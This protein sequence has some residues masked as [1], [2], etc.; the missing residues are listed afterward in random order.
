VALRECDTQLFDS[1]DQLMT[2]TS[3]GDVEVTV[4]DP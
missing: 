2:W 1:S 4:I 3:A